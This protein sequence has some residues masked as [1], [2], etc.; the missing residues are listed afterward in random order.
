M[1]QTPRLPE[2]RVARGPSNE[3]GSSRRPYRV[4]LIGIPSPRALPYTADAGDLMTIDIAPGE[5]LAG[6]LVGFSN[7]L[8][9]AARPIAL[10]YFRSPVGFEQ[11]E[12]LS[13]VTIADRAI[14]EELRRRIAAR[15]PDHGILGEEMEQTPGER[16]TWYLDPIDGTKSFISG[17]PLFGT[18]IAVA[19]GDR[20]TLGVIDMPALGE[21]WVGSSK[22]AFFNDTPARVSS[23]TKLA[24]AQI[25]TSSP[26]FFQARRMAPLRRLEP[27]LPVPALRRRLL[28]VRPARFRPLRPRG[29]DVAEDLR[30][31]GAD[32]R[33]SKARAGSSAIGTVGLS[34]LRP[35]AASSPPPRRRSWR[36][37]STRCGER[38]SIPLRFRP[39]AASSPSADRT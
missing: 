11:K 32:R 30:L 29:R 27:P 19:D 6:E 10:R 20:A 35:T 17:M 24:E 39:S 13:P 7:E 23:V 8:A 2:A 36:R 25:Y 4:E 37:R 9:D 22:G 28:P 26:D 21:R 38:L 16:Y 1:R 34:R 31:H 5:S 3:G 15:Y 12:D 33:W 14:E 18:L